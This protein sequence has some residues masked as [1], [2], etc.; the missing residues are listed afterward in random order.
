MASKILR[1]TDKINT[2]KYSEMVSLIKHL[3]KIDSKLDEQITK[4][5]DFISTNIL[6]CNTLNNVESAFEN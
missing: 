2:H 4:T 1:S 5:N 6:S 3:L